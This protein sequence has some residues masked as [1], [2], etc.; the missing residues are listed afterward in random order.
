VYISSEAYTRDEIIDAETE[1][2]DALEYSMSYTSPLHFLRRFSKAAR[3]DALTH[4]LCKYIIE[5]TLLGMP[6]FLILI[7]YICNAYAIDVALLKYLPSEL[8]AAAI[9]IARAMRHITPIWNST[10]KHHTKYSEGTPLFFFFFHC[11]SI[12]YCM[13]LL[14]LLFLCRFLIH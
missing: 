8:A 10:I 7:C 2:L 3:S 14:L 6:A 13:F 1:V 5:V 11:F 12:Q 4:S 9:Y